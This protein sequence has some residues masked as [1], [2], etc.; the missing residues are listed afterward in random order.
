[1]ARK[2]AANEAKNE[3][4]NTE[5]NEMEDA[6]QK[7]YDP[8]K[9]KVDLEGL[10]SLSKETKKSAVYLDS[11]Q[12]RLLVDNYYATQKYRMNLANQIRAVD[13]GFDEVQDGEQPAIAWLLS[14]IQNR[15]N[16]IKKLINE[17]GKANPF[18][19]WAMA[20]KGIG[21]CFAV[22]LWSYIDINK[23]HHANQWLSYAGLN[24]NNAPWLGT[25]K[26]TKLVNSA[27]EKFGMSPK[28]P[29]DDNVLLFVA[30]GSGRNV[31]TI[32]AGYIKHKNAVTGNSN[33]KTILIKYMAKPPYNTELKK[34]C[35]LIGQSFIKVSNRGSLYGEIYKERKAFETARNENGDYADQAARLL[36]EKNYDKNTD[37]YAYLSQG[38][39][40]PAH[41]NM[42]SIRY[43]VKIF[44]THVF[45]ARYVYEYGIKPPVIYPIAFQNHIDY[46][47]PEVPYSNYFKIK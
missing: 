27:Y 12:A 31:N 30:N 9:V 34:I 3:T 11:F 32:K 37:T 14:D 25:E 46:I 36:K 7:F 24:D 20:I 38:K 6:E 2:T 44:M 1:M 42:R 43:A 47:E 16:Q 40:S 13:Q 19:Q 8:N 28:D 18:C 41:I 29:V 4:V 5:V 45:E 39:L 23:C 21:P 22:N 15:E 26:A 33:E 10:A 35:F 17:Y